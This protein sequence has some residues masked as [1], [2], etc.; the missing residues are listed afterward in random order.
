MRSRRTCF[1]L[2]L[3]LSLAVAISGVAGAAGTQNIQAGAQRSGDRH[4]SCL[5]QRGWLP[6]QPNAVLLADQ[7]GPEDMVDAAVEDDHG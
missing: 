5:G 3:G 6:D 7:G 4:G 2:A 1:V